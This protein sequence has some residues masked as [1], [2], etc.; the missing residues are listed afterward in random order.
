MEKPRAKPSAVYEGDDEWKSIEA[1]ELPEKIQGELGSTSSIASSSTVGSRDTD[2]NKWMAF[3]LE[4]VGG[5]PE[6]SN[7]SSDKII[8]TE[9]GIVERTA[10]WGLVVKADPVGGGSFRAVGS[11]NFQT[12]PESSQEHGD[13]RHVRAE[14]TRTSEESNYGYERSSGGSYIPRVSQE[15][16]E[17]LATLQQTFVVS[18]ARKPECPIMYASSGFFG[19]TGYSSEEVVGRNW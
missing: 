14:S 9:A 11:K 18:D 4:V 6:K 12:A 2:A 15:L 19:M 1:F 10:E 17:A 5:K 7:S 8:R 13:Q 3:D 16:K